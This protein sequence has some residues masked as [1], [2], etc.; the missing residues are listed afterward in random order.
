M[1]RAVEDYPRRP[2]IKGR[3]NAD[4]RADTTGTLLRYPGVSWIVRAFG[5][6]GCLARVGPLLLLLL[7]FHGAAAT[8]ETFAALKVGSCTYQNVT[9]T[10]KGENFIIIAHSGGIASIKT[11]LLPAKVLQRLGYIP[12]PAPKK[13]L[14]GPKLWA[15]LAQAAPVWS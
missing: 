8:Q 15:D 4:A 6:G 7:T 13:R 12:R 5:T 2:L 10:T 14:T 9:V 11:S 3:N 1:P